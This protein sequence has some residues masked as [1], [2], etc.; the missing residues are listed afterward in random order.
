MAYGYYSKIEVKATAV[1]E[2]QENFPVAL[3]LTDARFGQDGEC[4][5]GHVEN[6]DTSG[7]A[8]T[9]LTVPADIVVGPNSDGS[10][11]WDHEVVSYSA[12]TGQLE[13]WFEILG[14]SST[15]NT[16]CYLAYGDDS[17]TTSQEDVEGTWSNGYDGVFHLGESTGSTAHDSLGSANGTYEGS[18]PTSVSGAIGNSQSSDG[19]GDYIEFGTND[20]E[21]ASNSD[22]AISFW[23]YLNEYGRIYSKRYLNSGGYNQFRV[24][25]GDPDLVAEIYDG[26]YRRSSTAVSL[27]EWLHVHVNRKADGTIELAVNG[28]IE[29]SSGSS[30]AAINTD[31]AA[32]LF[33]DSREVAQGDPPVSC[34]EDL[35]EVFMM[36]TARTASWISTSYQNQNAPSPDGD[37]WT[38]L[39]AA[40]SLYVPR[41]RV[42]FAR[43]I[44]FV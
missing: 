31:A 24:R 6:V 12:S 23:A 30:T 43:M 28:S 7:G 9:T 20:F 11:N 37:F 18:L 44:G 40:Q 2:D 21:Y 19:T 25:G 26:A 29:D 10:S 8:S 42:T 34:E 15:V 22:F 27:D 38:A 17:V 35:D 41:P 4:E 3:T 33:A 14:L 16:D 5:G 13:I 39:G 36:S 32:V 1:S